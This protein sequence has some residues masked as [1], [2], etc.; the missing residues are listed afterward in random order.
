MNPGGEA[1]DS[2]A[3][4][5]VVGT[6]ETCWLGKDTEWGG[7]VGSS[8]SMEPGTEWLRIYRNHLVLGTRRSALNLSTAYQGPQKSELEPQRS[9]YTVSSQQASL[10]PLSAVRTNGTLFR[11]HLSVKHLH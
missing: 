2:K 5:E 7:R 9:Q 1:S 11:A 3:K 6:T 10:P 8:D 4:G